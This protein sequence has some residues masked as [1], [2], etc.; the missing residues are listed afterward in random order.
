MPQR[1]MRLFTFHVVWNL[2]FGFLLLLAGVKLIAP[3]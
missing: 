1:L 3:F 2:V